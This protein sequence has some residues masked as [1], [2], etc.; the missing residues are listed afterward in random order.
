MRKQDTSGG[1]RANIHFT[2]DTSMRM[3]SVAFLLFLSIII[4]VERT[5]SRIDVGIVLE[6]CSFQDCCDG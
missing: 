6:E 4:P 3:E 5:T 1:E 2:R